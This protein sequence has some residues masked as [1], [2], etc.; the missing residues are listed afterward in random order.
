MEIWVEHYSDLYFRETTVIAVNMD[1]KK[2]GTFSS[3]RWLSP[4]IYHINILR[5]PNEV[6][7]HWGRGAKPN[8]RLFE[9]KI[10]KRFSRAFSNKMSPTVKI[11]AIFSD[12]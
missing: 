2:C 6:D 12:C 5:N 3:F 1:R 9:S 7:I 11:S 8:I 4:D 10:A